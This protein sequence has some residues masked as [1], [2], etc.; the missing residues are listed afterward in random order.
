M[1]SHRAIHLGPFV[2]T[3]PI[4]SGGMGQVWH[5]THASTGLPVAVKVVR[6]ELARVPQHVATFRNEVRAMARLDH[7]CI[8]TVLDYGEVDAAAATSSD[9]MMVEGSPYLVMEYAGGG[10]LK[11]LSRRL[12]WA[13]VRRVLL[14]L[15][16]ALAHAHAQGVIHRDLKSGN[17]LVATSDDVRPGLKLADFGIAHA[18]EATITRNDRS[19][20]AAGTLHY[21]SR[22]QLAGAWRDYGPWTDLYGLA[23][24][25]WRLI[26]GSPPFHSVPREELVEAQSFGPKGHLP[27]GFPPAFE[28]W[29]RRMLAP[30]PR[31]RFTRAADAAWALMGI[32]EAPAPATDDDDIRVAVPLSFDPRELAEQD[33]ILGALPMELA[34]ADSEQRPGVGFSAKV[35][36]IPLDWRRTRTAPV[37]ITLHGAGLQLFPLRTIPMVGREPE[38]DRLW[39]LLVEVHQRPRARFAVLTGAPGSGK[40]TLASWLAARAHELGAATPMVA[41]QT[42]EREGAALPELVM[43]HL[44]LGG[45]FGPP[46]KQQLRRALRGTSRE[47]R[48]HVLKLLQAGPRGPLERFAIVEE[49]FRVL[50]ERSAGAVRSG[51]GRPVVLVLDDAE[52][53]E[54]VAFARWLQDRQPTHPL[55]IVVLV[56]ARRADPPR[57][58]AL[59]TLIAGGAVPI[60]LGPLL[61]ADR[62]MLV[63]GLLRLERSLAARVDEHSAGNPQLAVG[64]VQDLVARHALRP[65]EDGFALRPGEELRIPD[66]LHDLWSA[67]IDDVLS[68]LPEQAEANLERAAILGHD[69]DESVWHAVCDDPL[70]ARGQRTQMPLDG[71]MR[72]SELAERLLRARL[73][74]ETDRGFAFH[75]AGVRQSLVR[76]AEQAGRAPQHHDAC[77]QALGAL[78]DIAPERLGR[79]LRGSGQGAEAFEHLV[80]AAHRHLERT[81]YRPG[82]GLLSEARAVLD[83]LGVEPID[84]RW[85]RVLNGLAHGAR[86]LGRADDALRYALRSIHRGRAHQW[87]GLIDA[88]FEAAQSA[89]ALGRRDDAMPYLDVME[90][91]ATRKKD[92]DALGRCLFAKGALDRDD[93]TLLLRAREVFRRLDDTLG[94]ANVDRVLG[95][96]ALVSGDLDAAEARLAA[97]AMTYQRVGHRN[98]LAQTWIS[99]VDV[100]RKGGRLREADALLDE[101]LTLYRT[102]DLGVLAVLVHLNLGLLRLAR[103]NALGARRAFDQAARLGELTH[104]DALT[105]ASWG[106]LLAPLAILEDWAAYETTLK[107]AT[108]LLQRTGFRDPD[109]AHT[110]DRALGALPA[111]SP[112]RAATAAL[113]AAQSPA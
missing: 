20:H 65:T 50:V 96:R 29:L 102:T 68:G 93:A 84:P 104:H 16:D 103:G 110:L 51:P 105:A 45:L 95:R 10:S 90:T 46:L 34:L 32:G 37:P 18:F 60:H 67:R 9:G 47:L 17:V 15:L 85:G 81:D 82:M 72:R 107:R 113:V 30:D 19:E 108:E 77:V 31:R 79:H 73:V 98:T 48:T 109:L 92:P 22:E 58:G 97:A 89:V 66:A 39:G 83:E 25:A 86:G 101:L 5:G 38:R 94:M 13:D 70:A 49:L 54:P 24:L 4:A 100:F 57:K 28:A 64:L 23:C 71:L 91:L 63:G 7:P 21:M 12:G 99:L 11:D 55:P 80:T 27:D 43:Q 53:G 87:P 33:T 36:P 106:S 52:Q 3:A 44:R 88:Y 78:P 69:V 26:T 62:S 76:R 1:P 14:S 6:E 41:D 42:A 35:P 40:T 2:L 75:V 112:L 8:L 61:P 74:V 56:V 111:R 59:H